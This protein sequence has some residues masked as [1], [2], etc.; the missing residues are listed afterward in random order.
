MQA[1]ASSVLTTAA[2][3]A[4]RDPLWDLAEPRVPC[5]RG[6]VNGK[7]QARSDLGNSWV[8]CR[9]VATA[10]ALVLAACPAWGI[11]RAGASKGCAG[12]AGAAAA[13]G[14]GCE[15]ACQ[16][17]GKAACALKLFFPFLS[18]Q[19]TNLLQGPKDY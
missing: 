16:G 12:S 18:K 10:P 2:L 3:P 13:Q 14:L 4:S 8:L 15:R 17:K 11:R 19:K 9:E 5:E 1:S 7:A 6:Q